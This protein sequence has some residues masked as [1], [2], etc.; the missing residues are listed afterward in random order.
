MSET[1]TH[2]CWCGCGQTPRSPGSRFLPG[3]D[4]KY[5]QAMADIHGPIP[6]PTE[7]PTGTDSRVLLDH[8]DP[9]VVA[10]A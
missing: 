9:D 4:S 1:V 5:A 7:P 2:Q 8:V 3:H 10:S 6:A